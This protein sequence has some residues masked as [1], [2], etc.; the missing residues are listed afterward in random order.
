VISIAKNGLLQNETR[1]Q[2]EAHDLLIDLNSW[3]IQLLFDTHIDPKYK[4]TNKKKEKK[5]EQECLISLTNHALV[6]S[7]Q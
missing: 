3:S 7:E 1:V 6:L 5:N 4:N 2:S